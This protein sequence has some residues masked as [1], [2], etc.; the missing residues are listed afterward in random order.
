MAFFPTGRADNLG[1]PTMPFPKWDPNRW[2]VGNIAPQFFSF[3]PQT[4]VV[5]QLRSP[6]QRKLGSAVQ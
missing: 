2:N 3:I 5:F 6:R 4:G 1:N